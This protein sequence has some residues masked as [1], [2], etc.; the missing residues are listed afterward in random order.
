MDAEDIV[1]YYRREDVS[2]AM[3]DFARNR[4]FVGRFRDG[5]YSRRPDTVFYPGDIV[6]MAA[7]GIVSFHASV[8]R[9]DNPT[10]LEG[11]RR[12]GWDFLIDLDSEKL[13]WSRKVAGVVVEL[14]HAH[15]V[16]SVYMKFSGRAGFHIL[17]PWESFRPELADRFPE[18]P[19]AIGAYLQDQITGLRD[20]LSKDERTRVHIDS[21]A[22]SSRHL[23]RAP[24]SLNEK[25]W[26]V[27]IPVEDPWFSLEDAEPDAVRARPWKVSG[28]E[29]EALTLVELAVDFIRKKEPRVEAPRREELKGK[30]P[31]EFFAPCIKKLLEGVSDGRK[32]GEFI[33][34]AYLSN[35]GWG[36]DE[37]ERLLLEWNKRN[38]PPLRE[39]YLKSQLR[40]HM[41]QRTKLL[42][43]N[44]DRDG[45]YRDMGIYTP[46]CAGFKNPLA[47]T[48]R[49]YRSYRR[50][51]REERKPEKK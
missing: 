27:S 8:E 29:G 33:L 39:G 31:E 4:E 6:R 44:H 5:G 48:L 2:G 14:L 40:W 18:V 38:K 10:Q 42:P 1:A 9:W 46:E 22:I 47:Y 34:R 45:F 25:S 50:S 12:M 21:I 20:E 30:V 24:Y 13:E 32:R 28:K 49:R 11:A 23:I 7:S 37:I 51:T 43:P 3:A 15:G 35:L 26:L 36:W 17:V 19:R 16:E 41:R